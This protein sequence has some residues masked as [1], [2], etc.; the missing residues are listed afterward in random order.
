MYANPCIT[1]QHRGQ[2]CVENA[3][4]CETM[5]KANCPAHCDSIK[6]CFLPFYPTCCCLLD[7]RNHWMWMLQ[8]L[9]PETWVYVLGDGSFILFPFCLVYVLS[10]ASAEKLGIVQG[11]A[12]CRRLKRSGWP[13]NTWET[14]G[15]TKDTEQTRCTFRS[16]LQIS[17]MKWG[18]RET[19]DR[20]GGTDGWMRICGFVD[21]GT[22]TDRI[23]RDRQVG[24]E[25]ARRQTR[26]PD[27]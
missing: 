25:K 10:H 17:N 13:G 12:R 4:L 21:E 26:Q 22:E 14:Q 2:Q 6:E 1:C 24:R 5:W 19:C 20:E 9:I 3:G 23:S 11:I 18:C 8:Q 7:S 27:R 16:S 15:P